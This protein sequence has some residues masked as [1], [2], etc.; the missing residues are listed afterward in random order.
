MPLKTV[1]FILILL[2]IL[3]P[4]TLYPYC[5][6]TAE[7]TEI[8]LKNTISF[9]YIFKEPSLSTVEIQNEQFTRVH[10]ENLPILARHGEPCLPVKP[11]RILLPQSTTVKTIHIETSPVRTLITEKLKKI[12]IGRTSRRIDQQPLLTA[13][14]SLYD[15]NKL[16]P[17]K[18]YEN[19]GVQYYRGYPI[20]HLNLYPI[21]YLGN[22]NT[23]Y[24]YNQIS[25]TLGI[26]QTN[27]NPLYR[28]ILKD[29]IEITRFVDNPHVI[30]T[31]PNH[32]THNLALYDYVIIT[33]E[34]LKEAIGVYTLDDLI[35]Y[36][37]SQGLSCRY[38]TIEEIQNEYDGRDTQEKIRNFIK[39]AYTKWGTSW[40]LLAGDVEQVPIRFLYVGG[41]DQEVAS[42]IYYQCL[43]GDYN[44]DDDVRWGEK[45]D[46][47]DGERIDLY[48]EVYL[49]RA[50][51]DDGGDISAFV[52]KT[53]SYETNDWD[54]HDHLQH[55]LSVGEKVWAGPGGY[56]AGYVERCI[57][58]CTDYDQDTYGIPSDQ[59]T[60][61]KLYE[62][63][64]DWERDDLVTEIN[65]GVHIINHV[66][67][68]KVN[69]AMKLGTYD[70]KTLLYNKDKY[71]LLYSQACHSGQ[72][73]IMDECF[74]EV[75]VNTE[76]AGGFAAIMNSGAGYGAQTDYDGA[77]NR[78]AR[79]FFD[80]LFSSYEKISRIGVAHQDSKEDNFYRIDEPHMLHAYYDTLLFGDPYVQ[81]KGAEDTNANFTWDP[82][83]PHPGES[84]SFIDK[85]TGNIIY[86]E[87]NFDDGDY[88]F[89]A[90]PTHLYSQP[91]I[92]QVTLTIWDD[93]GE[94]SLTT[95]D[96]EV[97]NQWPP[98]AIASPDYYSGD[99]FVIEF[100]G[101]DSWDP[102]GLVISYEWDFD[103]GTTSDQVNPT[104]EF[105]SEGWYQVK[106]TVTDDD[107]EHDTASCN[108]GV[109]TQLPPNIP[110][111]PD[112]P[113]TGEVDIEYTYTVS[114]TD[115]ENDD[116]TY[117]W[118]WNGDEIVDQWTKWYPSGKTCIMSHQWD[119]WGIF[120]VRVQAKDTNGAE[121]DWSEPLIVQIKDHDDPVVKITKPENALYMGNSPV[122]PLRTPLIIGEIE[123]ETLASDT[124]GID[125]IELYINN[126]LKATLN[127]EP[128]I[129]LWSERTPLQFKHT[130]K[131][132]AYDRTGNQAS[133][134][135]IV[136]KFF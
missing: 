98:F 6:K 80:A 17:G 8:N 40:I 10:L 21:Q 61:M 54:T 84:I 76:K 77:D 73:E 58:H 108:I 22:R 106:L 49:G 47:V 2:I 119:L 113:T 74:A 124:S 18:L 69:G 89:Q 95:R 29:K 57:D 87:W 16:Y 120:T 51:V 9:R 38:K 94:T 67:H 24:Y 102:D 4:F 136:W 110:S 109:G 96:V 50:P 118:D 45:F 46:G 35:A 42:D 88:S 101:S 19:L 64:M 25:L 107:G 33:T 65:E 41:D 93:A 86:R 72:L 56:G 105:P 39:D 7:S 111:I 97:K 131:I 23:C 127:S 129:W 12:E 60:I 103:D 78:Y 117:G 115:P 128:Y 53:L 91:G 126:Q 48:A 66:G 31:Y 122:I 1:S 70:V 43:D 123:I 32:N 28:E 75:W 100:N 133:D 52:E 14:L 20:L 83:Y 134:E 26:E 15:K 71:N 135:L 82:G 81:I 132:T 125:H 37:E 104:H 116:I 68:G 36:R 130:I 90:N 30:N 63:D 121:S 112:G 55:H 27:I 79:E 62:R 59:Y 85:S 3:T 44:Y 11:L 5:T 114:A 13:I 34:E 92:Y 99:K